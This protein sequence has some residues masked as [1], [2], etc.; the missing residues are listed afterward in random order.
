M[1]AVTHWTNHSLRNAC[2]AAPS[3]RGACAQL[4]TL[5]VEGT[6]Y[7]AVYRNIAL[8]ERAGR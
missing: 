5:Y 7:R 2:G 8:L 3:V 4:A 6:Q 1:H